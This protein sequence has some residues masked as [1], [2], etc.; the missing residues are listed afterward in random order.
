MEEVRRAVLFEPYHLVP[1]SASV[2]PLAAAAWSRVCRAMRRMIEAARGRMVSGRSRE[3]TAPGPCATVFRRAD[4][5]AIRPEPV[6]WSHQ[7]RELFRQRARDAAEHR[8]RRSV[9]DEVMSQTGSGQTDGK[10]EESIR[11]F[12]DDSAASLTSPA[13]PSSPG[14]GTPGWSRS[15][16][17]TSPRSSTGPTAMRFCRR[18]PTSGRPSRSWRSTASRGCGAASTDEPHYLTDVHDH[19]ERLSN[20]AREPGNVGR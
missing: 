5:P 11:S 15:S 16:F 4:T 7:P 9:K 10:Y 17:P 1:G 6:A 14:S 20:R 8:V 2:R 3:S 12:F 13:S 19:G 18:S